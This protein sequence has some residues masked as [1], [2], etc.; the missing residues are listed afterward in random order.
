M[1]KDSDNTKRKYE[2]IRAAYQEWTAKAYK[3]VRMYTDEYIYVRLEEQF[4]LKPKTIENIL[5]YRTTY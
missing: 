1:P 3:G 5:Y 2:D 4:Y